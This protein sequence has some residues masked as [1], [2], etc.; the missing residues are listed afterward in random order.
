MMAYDEQQSMEQQASAPDQGRHEQPV[1][2]VGIAVCAQS[3]SSLEQIFSQINLD[4][5][6]SY[7]VAVRQEGVDAAAVLDMLGRQDRLAVTV[8]VDGERIVPNHIYIGGSDD[9]M[10]LEDGH[11]RI[12]PASEPIGHR[13]TIDTMLISL[14]EHAQ[15]R[16]IAVVLRGL[17]SDGTAGVAA[18]KKFGGLS[19]VESGEGADGGSP[20]EGG[21]ALAIADLRLPAQGIATHISLYA[22][23]VTEEEDAGLDDEPPSAI[24][25][26]IT[27][28][29]T[30]LRNVTSHDFH[31]YKRGTFTRRVQRRM[32]V[33]QIGSIE[34]YI[35]RLRASRDEVQNLFQDLLIGVTQFFRDPAEFEALE[36]EIPRLFEGKEPGDQLR[37]WVLGCATGEEAYSIAMLLREHMAT[38]D[39]PPDVQIFAT[40]L[41]A[42]AGDRAWRPLFRGNNLTGTA[43]TAGPLVRA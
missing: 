3:V 30:I 7:L 29:A 8:A 39:Y 9:M 31:G 34:A 2:I 1:V 4:L 28:I 36:R 40:D 22:G 35:E 20:E 26:Q 12:R 16:A 14:A 32:Q 13:G 18:T 41:D 24:E 6:A 37:V 21:G 42:R 33:L 19:I 25:A 43:R 5:G 10:T 23:N 15:E 38:M 11:I 17:E 27:Q